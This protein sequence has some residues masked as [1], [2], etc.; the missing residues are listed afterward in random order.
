MKHFN[1]YYRFA[2][3]SVLI[4]ISSMLSAQTDD[5]ELAKKVQNPV[6]D[7][8]SI[9]F[10]NNIGFNYG[11]E[12]KVFNVMNI[13]PVVPFSVGANWNLITRTIIP[14]V[15]MPELMPSGNR[16]SGLGDINI[17]AFL[18]PSKPKKL[19][20]G[21]GPCILIPSATD[22]MLGTG[23]WAVGPS[24]V[25]IHM[26]NK[27]VYGFLINNVWS[28]A[29]NGTRA[30]V[31]QMVLQPGVNYNFKKG[32]YITMSPIITAN[33]EAK[34]GNQWTVPLGGGFGKIVRWGKLPFNLSAQ[35][36]YN[37]V[38]PDY[39]AD[40]TLRLQIQMLFPK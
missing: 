9:P 13:Q 14:V 5:S 10:Q 16:T 8:I 6:S 29:G 20:W 28:F 32:T 15:S 21:V 30:N 39:G 12:E 25:L 38:T 26:S 3:V 23:K 11:P 24:F 40:W 35:G 36:F 4:S 19:I 33:W 34:S 27:W 37:V 18:S 7:L 17:T 1:K 22:E 31:N 2:F